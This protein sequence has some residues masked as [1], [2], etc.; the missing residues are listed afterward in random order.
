M[1]GLN[2]S[3]VKKLHYANIAAMKA[4][5]NL[6][7]ATIANCLANGT[8]YRFVSSGAT[9]TANDRDI[10]ITGDGGNTRWI[11]IAGK[12][13]TDVDY[14]Q[15]DTS[16]TTGSHSDGKIY[17][18]ADNKCAA[19]EMATDV[20]LQVGQEDLRLVYNNTG[21]TIYNGELVY[22]NGVY[23]GGTNNVVT[24]ALAKSDSSTIFQ[25]QITVW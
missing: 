22:T 8:T 10:L 23:S 9:Y 20:T 2:Q 7:E 19:I 15:L 4:A 18:D 24:I 16:P 14:I 3:Q 25:Q 5:T 11:G 1:S 6:V 12:Y 13:I 17:Y 21:A